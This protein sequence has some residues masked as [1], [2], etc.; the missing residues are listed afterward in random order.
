LLLMACLLQGACRSID[1]DAPRPASIAL[2]RAD[3]SDTRLGRGVDALPR[4]AAGE[5]GFDLI[6][7]GIDALA[8]RLMMAARADR[9][10]DVQYYLIKEDITTQAVLHELLRAGDRGV[11]VRFLLDDF[12][13]PGL[14]E[15]L[16]ALDAHPAVEVRLVNPFANRGLRFLDGATDFRR[17]NRRMHNKSFTADNQATVIGGRNIADEYFAAREGSNFGDLDVFAVGSVVQEVSAMFDAYWNHETAIPIQAVTGP[18]EDP[19]GALEA[20]RARLSRNVDRALESRY[21]EALTSTILDI[22]ARTADRLTWCPYELV[23]DAPDKLLPR[24]SKGAET[25]LTELRE[26]IDRSR[27]EVL[28]VSPYFVPLADDQAFF[29]GLVERGVRLRVVTNS[30]AANNHSA[31]H[32]GYARARKPLLARGVELYEVREDAAVSGTERS[33]LDSSRA[34]LHTKAFAIDDER[35]FVGSFNFDPRSAYLNSEM[36][37]FLDD[38]ELVR[39]ALESVEEALPETTWTAQLDEQGR[40]RWLTTRDGERTVRTTEPGVG[41]FKRLM[42]DVLRMLPIRGQL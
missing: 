32:A 29:A 16:R 36:G 4:V 33:G 12:L 28:I 42:V 14:D 17:V 9:S 24:R 1:L 34:T 23:H 19:D 20:L 38:P 40:L 37:I 2:A 6:R 3:T 30:L 7:D 26:A 21:A 25:I 39:E 22:D 8:V 18:L 35:L 10:L 15:H 31:V 5:S 13:T 41:F 27:E 11:R